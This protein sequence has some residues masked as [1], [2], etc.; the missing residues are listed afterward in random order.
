MLETG[1]DAFVQVAPDGAGKKVRNLQLLQQQADGSTA[2]VYAQIIALTDAAGN[3]IDIDDAE[4][5]SGVIRR[6]DRIAD[7]LETLL[8]VVG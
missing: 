7:L 6:L 8:G 3:L 1:T 5:K 4:Y 2:T